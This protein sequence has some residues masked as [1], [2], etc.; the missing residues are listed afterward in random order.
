[1][2]ATIINEINKGDGPYVFK[3]NGQIHHHIG[4]LIPSDNNQ[5]QYV[6]LYIFDTQ[7]EISNRIKALHKQEPSEIDIDPEIVR[8][9]KEML[10]ENNP[11]VKT[12]RHARDMLE[13]Y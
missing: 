1:M 9:L 5:P 4:S 3:I 2:G 13:K 7:N 10:D 12:F 8:Q 11:L 6:E